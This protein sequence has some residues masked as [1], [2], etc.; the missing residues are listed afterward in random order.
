MQISDFAKLKVGME[1][2]VWYDILDQS[3]PAQGIA[4][5]IQVH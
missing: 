1:V 2:K 3:L 5:K 4:K